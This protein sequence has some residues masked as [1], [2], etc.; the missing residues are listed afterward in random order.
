M[1]TPEGEAFANAIIARGNYERGRGSYLKF[2]E[3]G[4]DFRFW[5]ASEVHE[6]A[7]LE[8]EVLETQSKLQEK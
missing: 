3:F 1:F 2:Y 7:L 8:Y 5:P 4:H 6:Y